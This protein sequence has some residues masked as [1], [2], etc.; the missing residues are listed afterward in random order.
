MHVIRTR[1]AAI[2]ALFVALIA[3]GSVANAQP[4]GD[5]PAGFAPPG[6]PRHGPPMMNAPNWVTIESSGGQTWDGI[7]TFDR[8]HRAMSGAWVNRTTGARV[9]ARHMLVTQQGRQLII[10]RPGLG[11]YVGTL[12]NHGTAITGTMSWVAGRFSAHM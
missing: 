8:S 7:W 9:Y 2:A 12:Q 4:Y 6:P 3:L 1:L 5:G 10:A 11:N